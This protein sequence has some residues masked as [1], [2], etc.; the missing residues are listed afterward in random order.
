MWVLGLN[1]GLL[2]EESALFFGGERGCSQDFLR[3]KT[4]NHVNHLDGKDT[5]HNSEHDF[6]ISMLG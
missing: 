4:V 6:I 2:E 5:F 3:F 1:L